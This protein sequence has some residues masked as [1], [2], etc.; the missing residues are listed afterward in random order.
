MSG[1]RN[2][3]QAAAIVYLQ[4]KNS[5]LRKHMQL[6]LTLIF[7]SCDPD[8]SISESLLKSMQRTGSSCI[9]KVSCQ[10]LIIV[11]KE[12]EMGTLYPKLIFCVSDEI[13]GAL[14]V[15]LG[16]FWNSNIKVIHHIYLVLQISHGR[17]FWNKKQKVI[18]HIILTDLSP[19]Q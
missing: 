7:P 14:G 16:N 10:K 8:A 12:D 13:L 15:S 9:M 5:T 17:H 6:E 3:F 4:T 19:V 2:I 11:S 18:H 1:R